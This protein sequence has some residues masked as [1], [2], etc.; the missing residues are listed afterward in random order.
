MFPSPGRFLSVSCRH[1]YKFPSRSLLHLNSGHVG[2][3]LYVCFPTK[4]FFETGR[5]LFIL[6]PKLGLAH[7]QCSRNTWYFL[8]L[9]LIEYLLCAR[10]C[11]KH[12]TSIMSLDPHKESVVLCVR[13]C[14]QNKSQSNENTGPSSQAWWQSWDLNSLLSAS[15]SACLTTTL[16]PNLISKGRIVVFHNT[17]SD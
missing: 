11:I 4:L 2:F 17:V 15:R 10:H 8:K 6:F 1:I 16:P 7:C 12:F 3:Y 14:T 9:I 5:C 13:A